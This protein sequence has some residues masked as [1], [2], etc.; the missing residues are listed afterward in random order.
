LNSILIIDDD[1]EFCFMLRDYLAA[2][3]IQLAMQHDGDGGLNALRSR[4]YDMVL[5]DVMLP[6]ADGLV[7][8]NRIKSFSS[9]SVLLL[10]AQG[11]DAS[12]IVGLEEGADDYLPKP[13]NPRELVARIRAVLRRSRRPSDHADSTAPDSAW[14]LELHRVARQAYY[15]GNRLPLTEVEFS[16]LSIFLESP[17][18][19]LAR[20]DLVLRVFQRPFHPFDRSL[21]VHISHLRRKLDP[22]AQKTRYRRGV[23]QLHQDHSQHGIS[24]FSSRQ[25]K[26]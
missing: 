12:R 26:R 19:V 7:I 16:L 10:S 17:G 4:W 2:H 15:R 8:L 3:N 13:F 5:L 20:E 23:E 25:E 21:D 24:F 22:P 11:N 6:D 14:G 1:T 18:A 9:S